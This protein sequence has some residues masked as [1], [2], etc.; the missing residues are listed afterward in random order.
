LL[1]VLD[2]QKRLSKL[3]PDNFSKQKVTIKER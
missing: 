3:R 1:L 2:I